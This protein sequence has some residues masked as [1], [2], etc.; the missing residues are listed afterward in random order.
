MNEAVY[1]NH[2]SIAY[3]T[4]RVL[5]DAY[6]QIDYGE[7]VG[8]AG[9]NGAGKTTLLKVLLGLLRPTSGEITLLGHSVVKTVKREIRA[10]IGYLPQMTLVDPRLPISAWDVVC[11]SRVGRLG[12]L[13]RPKERDWTAAH[14]AMKHVGIHHLANRPIGHLSGG[15]RQRVMLARALAQEPRLLLLDEP[16]ASLDQRAQDEL[17]E[18]IKQL[19]DDHSLT[20]ILVSHDLELISRLCDRVVIVQNGQIIPDTAACKR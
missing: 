5:R 17:P 12:L 20:T 2:V 15:E 13:Q 18:I 7:F 1:L 11:S 16:T 4:H 19:H 6:L 3:G 8:I 14:E 10:K 9:P